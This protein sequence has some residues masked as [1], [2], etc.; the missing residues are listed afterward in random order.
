MLGSL[1]SRDLILLGLISH[2]VLS[3]FPG[4]GWGGGVTFGLQGLWLNWTLCTLLGF[5][6]RLLFFTVLL[7]KKGL[8]LVVKHIF[9]QTSVDLTLDVLIHYRYCD[10][11]C[12]QEIPN[13]SL[14]L[15]GL[16]LR[17]YG[18]QLTDYF[19]S[20]VTHVVLDG[21]LFYLFISLFISLYIYSVSINLIYCVLYGLQSS[22]L[23][24]NSTY[25]V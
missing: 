15:L 23:L 11:L 18:A 7:S 24:S 2:Y 5:F 20:K 19:D 3:L 4:G 13:C 12:F 17:L 1:L 14:Q 10:V 6:C 22:L 16:K 25:T 21:R 9:V 8:I